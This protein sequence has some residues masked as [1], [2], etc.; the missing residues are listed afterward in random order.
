MIPRHVDVT[1]EHLVL[2]GFDRTAADVLTDGL[3][4]ELRS[5]LGRGELASHI[6]EAADA[7]LSDIRLN[8]G[9][10]ASVDA[11]GRRLAIVVSRAIE[12]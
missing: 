11:I 6:A 1:I 10:P 2:E 3:L 4:D 5:Y 8:I 12:P 9:P 7:E